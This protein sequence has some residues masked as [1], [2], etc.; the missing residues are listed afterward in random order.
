MEERILTVMP[1]VTNHQNTKDS[2][3]EHDSVSE[4]DRAATLVFKGSSAWR[5]WIGQLA[6]HCKRTTASVIDL[7][8]EEYA[9]TV[10]FKRKLPKRVRELGRPRSEAEDRRRAG[11]GD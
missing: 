7:A 6:G 3:L 11:M 8:L 5:A 10:G 2:D 4:N 9:K 1:T